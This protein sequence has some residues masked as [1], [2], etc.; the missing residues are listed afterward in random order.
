M[1]PECTC[2]VAPAGGDIKVFDHG[3]DVA[4]IH[5]WVALQVFIGARC[6]AGLPGGSWSKQGS[7]LKDDTGM[8]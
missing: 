2:A 8:R 3:I 6:R 4:Q 7:T 1:R 5:G